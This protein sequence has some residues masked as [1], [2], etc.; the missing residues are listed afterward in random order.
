[1]GAG[2]SRCSPHVILPPLARDPRS[3]SLPFTTPSTPS[4]L[5]SSSLRARGSNIRNAAEITLD[6]CPR[7]L[8]WEHR[9]ALSLGQAFCRRLPPLHHPDPLHLLPPPH[10]PPLLFRVQPL[11]HSFSHPRDPRSRSVGGSLS[12]ITPT[13]SP[14]PFP[15]FY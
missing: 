14:S 5:K 9:Y 4:L 3:R 15:S 8:A 1:M 13:P 7:N 10:S 2:G 6:A 12:S 11:L